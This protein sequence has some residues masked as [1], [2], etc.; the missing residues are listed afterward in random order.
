MQVSSFNG[1]N[2]NQVAFN[3]NLL[4]A[5]KEA[6]STAGKLIK[7]DAKRSQ[8]LKNILKNP[9]IHDIK[10]VQ[11]ARDVLD[12]FGHV[13]TAIRELAFSNTK[14][15]IVAKNAEGKEALQAIGC[16]DLLAD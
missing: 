9:E 8:E 13:A 1:Q 4:D 16:L 6:H 3:G 7:L 14:R 5:C 11:N 10:D 2:R 12:V 15:L